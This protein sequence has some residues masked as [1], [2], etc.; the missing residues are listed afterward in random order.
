MK[1]SSPLPFSWLCTIG[2]AL[3]F[4][5]YSISFSEV[6]AEAAASS[7]DQVFS[8]ALLPSAARPV[9]AAVQGT[10]LTEGGVKWS[11][12]QGVTISDQGATS[13]VPGGAHHLI[14]NSVA[15]TIHLHADIDDRGSGFTG[16]ALGRGDL[17]GNFWA[18]LSLLFYVSGDRYNLLVESKDAI[19]NV[20]KTILHTDGLNKLDIS[21]NTVTRAVTASINDKVV[22]NSLILP[23][24]VRLADIT[25]AGFRFNEPVTA[26]KPSVSN[27]RAEVSTKG[28]MRLNPVDVGM[29]FLAPN[30]ESILIWR[31]GKP[32]PTTSLAYVVRD[33]EGRQTS[34]GTGLLSGDGTLTVTEVFPRGYSEI[35][36]PAASQTF[37][38]V[39]LEPHVG[40]ADPFFCMDSALSGLE[41]NPVRQASLIQSLSRS[42]IAMSRERAGADGVRNMYA[43][44]KVPILEILDEGLDS[45]PELAPDLEK[46]AQHWKVWGGVEASNEPDL[47]AF[48]ADQYVPLVK[49]LS[50][51]LRNAHSP[52]PLVSGVFATAPPGPFFDTC[53]SN[54]IL[55]DSDAV[56]F[57]SYD[58]AGDVE[59]TVARYRAWLKKGGKEGMPLWH[60]ECG[61][62]WVLGPDRPPQNQDAV[63]A[64]E[65]SA[66]A[67]ESKVCGVARYFPFVYVYYEEG[68]K[69]FGMMGREVTP[70]RSMAAYAACI[71][72]LSGKKY[73]GDIQGLGNSVKLAR[74]F[75]SSSD[76]ECVA[77]I[78]TGAIDPKSTIPFPVKVTRAA[79]ADGR[80]LAFGNGALPVPDGLA[81]VW[82]KRTDLAGKL[83]ADTDAMR[84]YQIGRHPLVPARR[85][86][87]LVFQFLSQQTPSRASARGY[88]ITSELAHQLPLTVRINNL[89]PSPIVFTPELS[90]PGK[91][92]EKAAP[93]TVPAMGHSDIAWKL[94]AASQLDIAETR[95]ISL[96]GR[97]A[98]GVQPLPLAIPFVMEGTL[99]QHLGKHKNHLPL[100]ITELSHWTANI[101]G[102]GRSDFSVTQDGTWRMGVTFTGNGDKWAYPKFNLSEKIDP[103][104]YSGFLIRA[105]ILHDARGVAVIAESD[106]GLPSFWVSDLFPADGAWH[107]V[108]VP[109]AEFKVGPGGA[110]DQNT[111]LDPTAWKTI[112]IGM[113]SNTADNALEVSHFLLVGG[114]GD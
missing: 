81:Y 20:D 91:A 84:L 110:G 109:F 1:S 23:A 3:F 63:S 45:P 60:T 65:I 53:L 56:S 24:S 43:E 87:S 112:S 31:V 37:G 54:G 79:G 59:G 32:D 44:N 88:L 15:G 105:R 67:V 4:L 14:N 66:K 6:V 47:K 97:A 98:S 18:N 50:Y 107:V 62:A 111:R 108:Y 101:A 9:G 85:A 70:L 75:G 22:L 36:F 92:A 5:I 83:K 2:V 26:G 30:Q 25:A 61:W 103:A 95:F 64:L 94:A 71:Q 40:P 89:S 69:N 38:L 99:E 51:A 12:N 34:S 27:Y 28:R 33:Y 113:G 8:D 16:I 82:I 11:A 35:Y 72:A 7:A 102:Q 73:L 80:T 96:S 76:A 100:P 39:A 86:S 17:S 52:A 68:A 77:V 41:L 48:P 49:T 29:F 104:D 55:D 74:V 90:L 13:S 21:V 57:H 10:S 58:R 114:N 93:V 106:G 19:A 46:L 42:G 78:Y